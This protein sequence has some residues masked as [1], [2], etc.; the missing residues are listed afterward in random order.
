MIRRL[1]TSLATVATV[2]LCANADTLDI[3]PTFGSS[4]WGSTYDAATQTI[5]YES[6]WTGRG[7]WLAPGDVCTDYSAYDE[8]V[9]ETKEN[10]IG[11]S[12]I[13]E[14][15]AEGVSTNVSIEK[16]KDKGSATL[17]AEHKNAIKQ[18][19]LQAHEAGTLTLTAAYL[20]NEEV[21]D[22]SLPVVLWEGEQAIDW[23]GNAVDLTPND[24]IKAKAAAGDKLIVNYKAE[25]GDAFKVIYVDKNWAGHLLPSVTKIETYN[26]EYEIFPL[27]VDQ[28]EYTITLDA[29][30]I[31]ILTSPD[32]Q[33]IKFCGDK[34]TLTKLTL[35]HAGTSAVENIAVDENAPVEY[36][37]LQ[38][39]RIAEPAE[40]G[41]YIRR[42]GNKASKILVK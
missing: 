28:T 23:W 1:L 20:Q 32:N 2:A 4:G 36:Y 31:A 19:Y 9:I 5:T 35:I 30:D 29:E 3:L 26:P 7:W 33:T 14:Y 22:P 17:N 16:G 6:A 18:I 12:I 15:E 34:V 21:V 38:G 27:P 41:I 8:I 25:E 11:Y 13:V 37:N 39:V 10:A 24:F 42:Q 40:G